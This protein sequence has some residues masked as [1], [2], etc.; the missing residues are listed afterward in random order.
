[1][2]DRLSALLHEE[3]HHLTVPP[4]DAAEVLAR[5]RALRRRRRVA[6]GL[7][8]VAVVAVVGVGAAFAFGGSPERVADDSTVADDGGKPVVPEQEFQPAFAAGDTL[9]LDG[10]ATAVQMDEV[11][12]QIYFTSAGLLVRTN[13]DGDSDGGAPFHFVLV[14]PDGATKKLGLTLG[15]VVPGVDPT[16]PLLAYADMKGE[17]RAGRRPRPDHRPGR[18]PRRRTRADDVGRL[19][20][21]PVALSGDLVFVGNDEPVAVNWRTGEVATT[22]AMPQGMPVVNGGRTVHLLG[23]S[24][25]GGRRGKRD[26]AA[27]HRDRTAT[28]GDAL[29]RRSLRQGRR[30]PDVPPGRRR[31]LRRPDRAST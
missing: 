6:Q 28:V 2:T 1:M 27:R 23:R 8:T 30:R 16:Q 7:S 4:A 17:H 10:G 31:D 12:Q 5:G 29:P 19:A 18:G 20:R 21:S 14:T 25:P 13:S 24:Q 26:D 3:A 22:G 9:Y 15:E 11:V